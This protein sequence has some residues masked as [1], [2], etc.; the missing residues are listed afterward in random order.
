[1]SIA[2]CFEPAKH[3]QMQKLKIL[4]QKTDELR[5][6]SYQEAFVVHIAV[7]SCRFTLDL[8]CAM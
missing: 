2:D 7:L 3:N 8:L 4:P 6:F 5:S 1:M